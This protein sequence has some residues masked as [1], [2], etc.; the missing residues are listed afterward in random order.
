MPPVLCSLLGRWAWPG[1]SRCRK[2]A[3]SLVPVWAE[4]EAA[5]DSWALGSGVL[6]WPE[7]G[8]RAGDERGAMKAAWHHP[9]AMLA[10]AAGQTPAFPLT[11][12]PLA[13]PHAYS[14]PRPGT[15]GLCL[16]S[17][18]LL[19][20]DKPSEGQPHPGSTG[21]GTA[22]YGVPSIKVCDTGQCSASLTFPASSIKWAAFLT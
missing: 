3:E 16:S 5:L 14:F 20:S 6:T 8:Q 22:S 17:W 1:H 18:R 9:P 2:G 19:A 12:R 15:K 10:E 11:R 21:Q 4:A 7:K 13:L